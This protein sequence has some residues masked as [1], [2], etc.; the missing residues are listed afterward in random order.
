MYASIVE[1]V[2]RDLKRAIEMDLIPDI[3]IEVA[4][5]LIVGF[6]ESAWLLMSMNESYTVD[7]VIDAMTDISF[8]IAAS[9]PAKKTAGKARKKAPKKT[10]PSS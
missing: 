1:P 6:L 10:G 2:K 3:D 8:P 9:A 7:R 5:F 4:A